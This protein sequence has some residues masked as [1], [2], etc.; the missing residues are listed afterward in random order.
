MAV[1][2]HLWLVLWVVYE[3]LTSCVA[4]QVVSKIHAVPLLGLRFLT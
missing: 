4:W 3:L 2:L 1:L